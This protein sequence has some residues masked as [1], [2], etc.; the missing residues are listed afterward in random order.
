MP[1]LGAL[2]VALLCSK[3]FLTWYKH[4][5]KKPRW[6]PPNWYGNFGSINCPAL[7]QQDSAEVQ[8]RSEV[9]RVLFVYRLFVLMWTDNYI[10]MGIAAWRVWSNGGWASNQFALS[11][12][13]V[14]ARHWPDIHRPWHM[15]SRG[16]Q[17][18]PIVAARV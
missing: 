13:A 8:S 7:T 9:A 11:A 10:V 5:V 4:D 14:Q 2:I 15:L 17:G 6:A 1:L 12:F 18:H 16:C 3:S